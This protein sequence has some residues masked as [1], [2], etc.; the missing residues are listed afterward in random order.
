MPS[1][2]LHHVHLVTSDIPGFCAFYVENFD[3]QIVFD[4]LIDGDRNVFLKIGS[5][6]IHLFES[7]SA[8]PAE[9]NAYHHLGMMVT[10]LPEVMEKLKANGVPVSE[11][12]TVPGGRFAMATAPDHVKIELFEVTSERTR[13]FFVSAREESVPGLIRIG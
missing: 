2:S 8:P 12:T 5:G 13:P 9:K 6:R 10:E 3:A 7:K 4:D 11:M 1:L